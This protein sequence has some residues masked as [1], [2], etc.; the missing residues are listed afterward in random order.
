MS[1][2]TRSA[3][4]S[5]WRLW[6]LLAC[7]AWQGAVSAA[8]PASASESA[9]K[10]AYLHRIVGLVEWPSGSFAG[11]QA[12]LVIVVAGNESVATDLEQIAIGRAVHG[13]QVA[14][15]RLREGEVPKDAHVLLVGASREA[16]LRELAATPGPLLVVTE[17]ESGHRLGAVLNFVIVAGRVR[18]T[19]SLPQADARGLRLSARL[20]EVAH[21]VEGRSR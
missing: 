1:A 14:V 13:R 21:A 9:V 10:A 20:L 12:P 17:Q 7:W 15:R 18:F 2:R 6:L 8:A 4:L 16:R 5:L 11:P 3:M 19:A